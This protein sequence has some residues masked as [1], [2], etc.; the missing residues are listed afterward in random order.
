[1][2][3]PAIEELVTQLKNSVAESNRLMEVLEDNKVEVRITYI[4]SSAT[5]KQKQGISI[6]RITQHNDYL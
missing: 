6:W 5:K 2:K 4:E 1:M 3:D